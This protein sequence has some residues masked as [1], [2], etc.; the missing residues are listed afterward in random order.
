MLATVKVG[1]RLS[2]R[3]KGDPELAPFV[4]EARTVERLTF[5]ITARRRARAK[6]LKRRVALAS[7]VATALGLPGATFGLDL[8]QQAIAPQANAALRGIET[9]ESA[10]SLMR[11]RD[12]L[13]KGRSKDEL[14]GRNSSPTAADE[15]VAAVGGS[16]TESIYA[17]AAE[18][19]LDGDY[20]LSIA[21]CESSLNP[22][23]V[24]AV[25]YYGLFQFDETTWSAYGYGSIY[26]PVAQS[27]TAARLIAAGQTSRWPNCA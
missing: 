26:D 21:Q 20:L 16:I 7:L 25:G 11:F 19:G 18:F 17:A 1:V 10:A 27:Y 6:R 13:I 3:R 15:P 22:S 24:N 2:R 5:G 12:K 9:T 23:A 4:L 8:V 14:P